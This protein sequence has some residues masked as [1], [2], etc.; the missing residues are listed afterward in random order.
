[1]RRLAAWALYGLG[2][3]ISRVMFFGWLYPPYNWLML[4]SEIIQGDGPGPWKPR[5]DF[6]HSI[7]KENPDDHGG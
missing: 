5:S 4:K 6:E 3:A 2:D 7:H 1:M